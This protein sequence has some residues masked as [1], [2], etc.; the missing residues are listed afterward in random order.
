MA[1]ML[2]KGTVQKDKFTVAGMLEEAGATLEQLKAFHDANYGPA[3]ARIVIVGDVDDAAI[4]RTLGSAFGDWQGGKPI[5][6]APKA[7]RLP[8][9]RSEKVVM[10]GKTSVTLMIGQPSTLKY[11]DPDYLALNMATSVL[12]SGFF[13]ARLLDV[14]R[15]QEGLTYGIGASLGG[16]TYTDGSWA[17]TGTFAPELLDKG[18]ASTTRELNRFVSQ[19]VTA[20]EL[21]N[22]K[23]T[24]T[25]SYKV[26]LSTTNGLAASLLN[27]LQRGYGPEWVDEY[28]RRI[29]ALT[30]DQVNAAIK[31]YL[32]PARMIT[33]EAGTMPDEKK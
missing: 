27:A 8:A 21:A 31:K 24:L 23:M 13:S 19:G 9:A 30:L 6:S 12:G 7:P 26:A 22:F 2:D 11:T 18:V 10:P 15:N 20:E 17:I 25:G 1:G 29:E 32:Q 16:D 14:I 4:N 28:P 3:A 33:V 5:P